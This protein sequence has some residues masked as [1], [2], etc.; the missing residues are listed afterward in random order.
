MDLH[1]VPDLLDRW[2][3]SAV[4]SSRGGLVCALCCLLEALLLRAPGSHRQLFRVK[5]ALFCHLSTAGLQL[6]QI[7]R[8]FGSCG[9]QPLR[10]LFHLH[11]TVMAPM[12]QH[13]DF[14]LPS[15]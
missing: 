1:K 10:R 2:M 5:V 12:L 8:S 9:A 15:I 3:T 4:C 7:L 6:H 13:R 11:K 14:L